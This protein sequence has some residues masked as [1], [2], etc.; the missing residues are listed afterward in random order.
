[1]LLWREGEGCLRR[2]RRRESGLMAQ[3]IGIV[4]MCKMGLR[5]SC[6][7]DCI[8]RV[9]GHLFIMF[10]DGADRDSPQASSPTPLVQ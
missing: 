6:I 5:R 2:R 9:D 7:D 3:D 8:I 10:N 1:M 4:T